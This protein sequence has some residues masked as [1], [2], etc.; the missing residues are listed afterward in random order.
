MP[1]PPTFSKL[2]FQSS[3]LEAV[4]ATTKLCTVVGGTFSR[5]VTGRPIPLTFGCLSGNMSYLVQKIAVKEPGVTAESVP[6]KH[7]QSTY[8]AIEQVCLEGLAKTMEP[9][10]QTHE[11]RAVRALMRIYSRKVAHDWVLDKWAGAAQ[12]SNGMCAENRLLTGQTR[13]HRCRC[14]RESTR[15]RQ[16]MTPWQGSSA[17]HVPHSGSRGRWRAT[18]SRDPSN[19]V[20]TA[21]F[22]VNVS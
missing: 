22:H 8:K 18:Y 14:P 17:G 1:P 9:D 13:P 5:I 6:S 11:W 15:R 4:E 21:S 3:F 20:L 10:A 2:D 7:V 19:D 12:E 16:T